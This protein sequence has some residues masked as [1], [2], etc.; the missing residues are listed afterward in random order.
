MA[1]AGQDTNDDMLLRATDVADQLIK[2]HS[3][4]LH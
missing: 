3:S 2:V 4:L 1:P